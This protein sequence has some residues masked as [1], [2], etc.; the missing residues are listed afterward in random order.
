MATSF[1]SAAGV[2]VGVE[3]AGACGVDEAVGDCDEV[4]GCDALGPPIGG[5]DGVIS[6]G[7][8]G[9]EGGTIGGAGGG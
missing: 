8:K 1:G 3:A 5:N 7:F 6:G 2:C 9:D 4:V